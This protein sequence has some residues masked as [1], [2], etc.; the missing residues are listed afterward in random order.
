MCCFNTLLLK[1][2][3]ILLQNGS[4]KWAGKT[5]KRA[6]HM[7]WI[8]NHLSFPCLEFRGS[9]TLCQVFPRGLGSCVKRPG[10]QWFYIPSI[11]YWT[12]GYLRMLAVLEGL[13]SIHG[14]AK[15]IPFSLG[16]PLLPFYISTN[17]IA[18]LNYLWHPAVAKVKSFAFVLS[19]CHFVEFPFA[20]SE[21]CVCLLPAWEVEFC[22]CPSPSC[23]MSAHSCLLLL[24]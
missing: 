18:S 13:F 17:Y 7:L 6:K 24:G 20:T 12:S 16:L 1:S 4:H 23:L 5:W 21:S 22:H 19:W 15:W 2:A 8:H 3:R 9:W 10:F 14:W 11:S